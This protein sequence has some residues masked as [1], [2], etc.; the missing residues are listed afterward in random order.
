MLLAH[1]HLALSNAYINSNKLKD[2]AYIAHA[3]KAQRVAMN[4]VS[5]T[6]PILAV[7]SEHLGELSRRPNYISHQGITHRRIQ[8]FFRGLNLK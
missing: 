6:H 1:A 2:E 7:F 4:C 5:G 8:E 3:Q